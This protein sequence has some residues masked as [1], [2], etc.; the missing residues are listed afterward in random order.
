MDCCVIAVFISLDGKELPQ[1]LLRLSSS[2]A[3]IG[4]RCRSGG[5]DQFQG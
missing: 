1:R 5:S 4:I 2:F 3:R